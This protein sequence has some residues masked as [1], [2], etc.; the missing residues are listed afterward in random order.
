MCRGVA[1][2]CDNIKTARDITS[3]KTVREVESLARADRR[4]AATTD[5]WDRN[6]WLLNT[7]AGVVDLRSGQ[8]RPHRFDDYMTKIT[9]V[10]PD[11]A[12]RIPT[13]LTFLNRVL[14][15]DADLVA[16]V[17]RMVGYMLTGVT[18]EHALFFLWGTGGNG[19]GTFVNVLI[20]IWN[21]YHRTSPIETF[22][23]SK[24]GSPSDR[25]GRTARRSACDCDRNRG[26]PP[27]GRKQNKTNNRRRPD[28]S[29]FHAGRFL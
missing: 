27:L 1:R 13:W 28:G 29:S 19:K 9:G 8:L 24:D 15:G 2:G 11:A 18:R 14:N 26:R 10:A 17:R 20:G 6:P 25:T 22:V 4:L 21:E 12:C 3:A 23:A 5:Q 7:P 16:F